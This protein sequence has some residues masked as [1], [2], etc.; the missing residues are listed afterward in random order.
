MKIDKAKQQVSSITIK[1]KTG[2]VTELTINK[3]T[4]NVA[5]DDAKF[6][7]NKKDFPDY[8]VID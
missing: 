8:T 5:I 6:K 3:F 2:D 1:G 4:P 7:F